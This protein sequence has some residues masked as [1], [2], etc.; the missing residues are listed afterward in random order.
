MATFAVGD[1]SQDIRGFDPETDLLD[2]GNVSV[3][4]LILG[5]DEN[6]FATVVFPWQPNQFQRILGVDGQGIRWSD[7]TDSNFAAVG[8]EHLRQD[9]GA[10]MSWEN[11]IGPAFDAGNSNLA[12]TVYIR[13]HEKD[14]VTLIDNF[15]PQ[16]DKINFLY[17]GTRERLTVENVGSDLVI[18]SEP[19]GQQF[20][21]TGVQKEDLIGA[22]LEF[23]FDQIEED[24][25]DRAFGFSPEQLALVDR[26]SLFTPEGGATDGS[27][28][29]PGEFVTAAGDAPGQ[30]ISQEESTRLI[31]ERADQVES[32]E[33]TSMDAG[34]GA[35]DPTST[36]TDMEMPMN[37]DMS[38]P[39]LSGVVMNRPGGSNAHNSCLLLDV[40][41][42]L[43]WG[44]GISGNLIIRNPMGVAIE[45]WQV[46]FLTPHDQF[47][48]WSGDVSVVDAGDG[49][50]LVTF[51]PADWNRSIPGNGEISI[52]FNAQGVGLADSGAL[53][54]ADF[55]SAAEAPVEGSAPQMTSESALYSDVQ[56]VQEQAAPASDGDGDA[57]NSVVVDD[58]VASE[59]VV[60]SPDD[61]MVDS[62]VDS[63]ADEQRSEAAAYTNP[64]SLDVNGDLY[65]GGMSGVLTIT[66]TSGRAVEN[67]SVSFETPHSDFQSWAGAVE[68]EPLAA[69]GNRVTLTPAAWNNAIAAGQSIDVSFN[70]TSEGIPNSGTLTSDLFFSAGDGA[71]VSIDDSI[72]TGGSQSAEDTSGTPE[73]LAT[74]VVSTS[75]SPAD[76]ALNE[77]EEVAAIVDPLA[78]GDAV[79]ASTTSDSSVADSINSNGTGLDIRTAGKKVVAYFEEWGIY[80]RD[81]LAKDINVDA[82]THINYSFFDVKANGDVKLFDAWAATDKRFGADEQV[83]RT[84]SQA[85]W[86][87]LSEERRNT[88]NNGADFTASV[89][90]DGSVT[91]TGVP[92]GWNTPVDYVGNLRQ[93]DLIKQLNPQINLGL[94][95]GGW[96]LSDEFSL[97]VDSAADREA[98][99]NSIIDTL[100]RFDF[101]TTVDFDWEY[102]G[103]GGD[104]GNA[105]SPDDGVNFA[106][107][108]KLLRDKLDQLESVSGE[109]Y[110]ISVA[111]AG[112]Y[113]KLA[114]LNL[115]G[116]DPYVD[117][118]NVM[119]YDFH[120]GWESQTGH[121]AAMTNDPGGYDIATAIEQFQ[122]SNINL[123][124]VILG[125]PTYTRAW[126]NVDAGDTFGLGNAG[127]SRQAPGSYEAGNYDQKD[128]ITG[129]A[130]GS[131]ELVWDDDAKAAFVYNPQTRVWSSIETPATIAGKAIY[132]DAMDLGGMMFWAL[133]NDSVGD[134]SLIGAA[135]DLLSGEATPDDVLARSVPF[136]WVLGG[137]GQFGLDD[138]N[139]LG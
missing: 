78:L 64:L 90:G 106:L 129:V 87:G 131:Y 126:G 98:F 89:N 116:I 38:S 19:I 5:Q 27:Q 43:W 37:M 134:Q 111:T 135:S 97:A 92:M 102:P 127:D 85:D 83:S 33:A 12:S 2:F 71:G 109:D 49:L 73:S 84:F 4:S 11:R 117:F 30:P 91:V 57:E 42:S 47:E 32:A 35:M 17:F 10:V 76:S 72:V 68:I 25:L 107:T 96:T 22:N 125:A 69:G 75:L 3:H 55:F 104:S 80:E 88:Y 115:S 139:L 81:F 52:S 105:S 50:N 26:S 7:L 70:A 114:N 44:G 24:L 138:F 74:Q 48:S 61:S 79:D 9:I 94:A 123:N 110:D 46:S 41:G 15:N 45:D 63:T 62:M 128:L 103:G 137:D 108:L 112:G 65:W 54:S 13:S 23:H 66:N 16:V 133:S 120:G 124:K 40:T 8:N 36:D 136:D 6:G 51:T 122:N 113:D 132:A 18:S 93:F 59:A 29:R 56:A 101:F 39:D 95:L 14:S 1:F 86:Q 34:M 82:L 121:Q 100:K 67:W 118:Y 60:L 31:Q 99:T 21:F 58:P 77:P 28:T 20:I 130:D 53:T 119:T